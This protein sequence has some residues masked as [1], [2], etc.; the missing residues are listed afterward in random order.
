ML[1]QGVLVSN[2]E[3]DVNFDR[4]PGGEKCLTAVSAMNGFKSSTIISNPFEVVTKSCRA[5]I[6]HTVV[7]QTLRPETALIGNGYWLEEPSIEL[8]QL[9]VGF[10]RRR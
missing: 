10:G 4:L 2:A 7:E 8:K 6:V 5:I 3:C 9:Q 1:G